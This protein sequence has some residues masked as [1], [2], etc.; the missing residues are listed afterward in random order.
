MTRYW[1]VQA[2]RAIK[3]TRFLIKHYE[4]HGCGLNCM[5]EKQRLEKMTKDKKRRDELL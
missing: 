2:D 3:I 5:E 4:K 1:D